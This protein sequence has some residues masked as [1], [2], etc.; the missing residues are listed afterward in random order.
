MKKDDNLIK[1]AFFSLVIP[2]KYPP[3]YMEQNS[4]P[5]L[6]EITLNFKSTVQFKNMSIIGKSLL[7]NFPNQDPHLERP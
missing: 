7:L 4:S 3:K 1:T 2:I 6:I 5:I